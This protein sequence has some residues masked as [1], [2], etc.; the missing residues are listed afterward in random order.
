LNPNSTL[1]GGDP[2]PEITRKHFEEGLKYARVS[3]SKMDLEKYDLF[4]K[5]SDPQYA[6]SQSGSQGRTIKWPGVEGQSAQIFGQQSNQMK[7]EKD[8]DIYN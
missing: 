4:R 5:K 7:I 6:S 2:V 1:P 8:D 3:V